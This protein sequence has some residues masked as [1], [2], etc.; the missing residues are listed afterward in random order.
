MNFIIPWKPGLFI[1]DSLE[2]RAPGSQ[3]PWKPGPL[4]ARAAMGSGLCLSSIDTCTY[5]YTYIP[6]YI[7]SWAD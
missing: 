4:E 6:V 1:N 7:Q 2:A 5:I 3:G